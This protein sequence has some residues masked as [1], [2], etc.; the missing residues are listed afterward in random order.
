MRNILTCTQFTLYN[1]FKKIR[2]ELDVMVLSEENL[3][4]KNFK[5]GFKRYYTDLLEKLSLAA[6]R[7]ELIEVINDFK[8]DIYKDH[9]YY[10]I[11]SEKTD[12]GREGDVIRYKHSLMDCML[13]FL[14]VKD[15]LPYNYK[16][17]PFSL[18]SIIDNGQFEVEQFNKFFLAIKTKSERLRLLTTLKSKVRLTIKNCLIQPDKAAY[19]RLDVFLAGCLESNRV[20]LLANV[21]QVSPK[22]TIASVRDNFTQLL[23]EYLDPYLYITPFDNF[24]NSEFILFRSDALRPRL[25]YQVFPRENMSSQEII[26]ALKELPQRKFIIGGEG[27][28]AKIKSEELKWWIFSLLGHH[29]GYSYESI[30]KAFY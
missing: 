7:V 18:E 16:I 25:Q 8:N 11:M 1:Q 28:F 17:D 23:Y 29:S 10:F 14:G 21:E 20:V 9:I 30:H 27:D 4:L 12:Y 3:D 13:D 5:T 26:L 22:H 24:V 6:S 2:K 15:K 19:E